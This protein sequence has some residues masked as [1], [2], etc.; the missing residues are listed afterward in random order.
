M[1]KAKILG[2]EGKPQDQ[3][4]DWNSA[5]SMQDIG[6]KLLQSVGL[7]NPSDADVELA[8]KA[9]DVF[10][11]KLERIRAEAEGVIVDQ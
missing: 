1:G 6:R 11:A 8:I 10:V 2:L 9:N 7:Q 5:Q 4:H 3:P